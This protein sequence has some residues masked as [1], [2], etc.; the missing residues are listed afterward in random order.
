MSKVRTIVLFVFLVVFSTGGTS[1]NAYVDSLKEALSKPASEIEHYQ[2]L[3]KLAI[4]YSDSSYS[5]SLEYWQKALTF[6]EKA[7]ARHLVANALHQIGFNYM[8]QGEFRLSLENL[9]NAAS[10]YEYLDSTENLAGLLNDIGLIYRNWGKYDK[11]LE[12][13]IRALELSR[14]IGFSEGIGIASNSIGQIHFYRENYP[15]AIEYFKE[16]LDINTAL[17]NKRAVAGASNNIASAYMELKRY[18]EALEYFLKSLHIYDSLGIAIGVAIIQ[19]NIGSLYFKQNLLDNALLYHQN[20]LEIFE[21]LNS[22]TRK[23]YTLKNLGQ[24]LFAQGKTLR[25]IDKYQEALDLAKKMELRDVER[26]CYELLSSCYAKLGSYD[27]AYSLLQKHIAIKDSILNAETVQKIEEL[28]AQ[29]ER[30]RQDQLLATMNSKLKSQRIVFFISLFSILVL[31]TVTILLVIENRRKKNA[32]QQLESLSY[33]V[34][35]NI[36]DNISSLDVI[37]NGFEIESFSGSWNVQPKQSENTHKTFFSHFSIQGFTFCYAIATNKP[38]ICRDFVNLNIF[39]LVLSHIKE[40]GEF[41][42]SL[43]SKLNQYLTNDPILR[44]LGKNAIQVFPFVVSHKRILS[45]CPQNMAF[46]QYG[47]FVLPNSYQWVNLHTDDIIYLFANLAEPTKINEIRKVVK[48]IDLIDFPEQKELA[49][50]FLHTMELQNDTLV[51][52]FKV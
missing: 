21:S 24:V 46:R 42:D 29:F 38:N 43:A 45:L 40:L 49:I 13:Y 5:K 31:V 30:D 33:Q 48:S 4:A 1:Q 50:N 12:N 44:S 23:C 35:K 7:G 14:Q 16:Y 26:D 9:E 41:S 27:Q 17:G 19:D 22:P 34:L 2:T 11:A 52:A 37:K 15:K 47:S 8:K 51:I 36:S 32:I 20:A 3:S 10:I 25:A 28:Q 6:A 18:D 39:N